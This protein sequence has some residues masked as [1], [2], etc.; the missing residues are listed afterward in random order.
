MSI[1][2]SFTQ[3]IRNVWANK[4]L[5]GW[6]YLFKLVSSLA[7]LLPL[8]MMFSASFARNVKAPSLFSE[9]DLSLLIDFVYHWRK[10]L[11]LYVVALILFCGMMVLA[12]VFLS[13]GFW[14]V[15]RDGTKKVDS[16]SRMERFFRYCG[17]YFWGML[18]IGV[19][20]AFLYFFALVIFLFCSAVLD[21][22]IGRANIWEPASG[23]MAIGLLV[24]VVLFFLVNMIG[25]YL[26]IFLIENPGQRFFPTVGKALRF[27]LTNPVRTLSLYYSLSLVSAAAIFIFLGSAKAVHAAPSFGLFI[28]VGFVVQQ[29]FVVFRCFY[30]LVYYSSQLSLYD[31]LTQAEASAAQ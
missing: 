30:R 10:T 3:G 12:F 27:V 26:K 4:F 14:G 22:V 29:M 23:R 11:P 24:G 17:K 1:L 28:L 6:M 31:K 15:L 2:R 16:N 21:T 19:V 5:I 25:D 20:T 18:K 13:G 8:H 7:L 9:F